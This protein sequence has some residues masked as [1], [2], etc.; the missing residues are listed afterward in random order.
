M[1][2]RRFKR[3]IKRK[4]VAWER[5]LLQRK[6]NPNSITHGYIDEKWR[7][8]YFRLASRN[9]IDVHSACWF[10]RMSFDLIG[11]F[12]SDNTWIFRCEFEKQLFS[13]LSSVAFYP[14]SFEAD[15]THSLSG[16]SA[17]WNSTFLSVCHKKCAKRI[18]RVPL[19]SRNIPAAECFD[20]T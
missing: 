2:E 19:R 7:N 11:Y 20:R 3:R 4:R 18:E 16:I 8:R 13:F 15:Q 12:S 14:E 6:E 10:Y 17:A 1:L 9:L 5:T